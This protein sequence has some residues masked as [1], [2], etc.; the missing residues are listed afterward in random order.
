MSDRHLILSLAKVVIAAAWADRELSQEET[1][2]LKDL[3]FRLP[4][5]YDDGS[6]RLTSKEW[7][8]LDMYLESPVEEAEQAHLIEELQVTLRSQQD[9]ELVLSALDQLVHADGIVTDEERQMVDRIQQALDEVDVS[10][11]GQIGRLLQGPI[12][13]RGEATVSRE[14]Y[15]NDFVRNKVFYGIQRRLNLEETQINIPED[16]LRRLA[17]FGGLM[18]RVAQVDRVVTEEEFEQMVELLQSSMQVDQQEAHFV[19]EVAVAEAT[20]DVDFLRLTRELAASIRPEEGAR[21]LCLLFA[22]ANADGFV[23]QAEI[24]QI[25]SIS[26]NLNLTHRQFIE[27]KVSIPAERRAS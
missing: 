1:N 2:S 22:V 5:S 8:I 12:Q 21:L 15:F 14:R 17:A 10:I 4:D 11:F 19:A 24:E 26:F 9:K 16:K 27:A 7:A 20:S 18:A 13:R 6:R 25:Y 23:T 3:L